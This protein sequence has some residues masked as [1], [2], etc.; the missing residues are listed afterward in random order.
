[1]V[2]LKDTLLDG[3]QKFQEDFKNLLKEAAKNSVP[4]DHIILSLTI[5]QHDLLHVRQNI[6]MQQQARSIVPAASLPPK[7]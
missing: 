3:Q 5:A 2:E 7:I 1:M 6:L 4:I